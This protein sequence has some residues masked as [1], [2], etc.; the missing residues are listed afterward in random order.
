MARQP[1]RIEATGLEKARALFTRLKDLGRDPIGLMEAWAAV[2]ENSTRT[3][4]DTG[5]APGGVP[6]PPSKRVIRDGGKTLVDKGNLESSIRS[7]ASSTELEVG[8]DGVGASSRFAYVHQFGFQG[9]VQVPG[10]DRTISEAFGLPLPAPKTVAV[11]PHSRA[12]NIPQREFLGIDDDDKRD[13]RE[14]ALELLR[15]ITNG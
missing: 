2:I 12:M 14:V 4:F 13:M 9:T 8:V 10:H 7:Q 3:R 6:W 5:R 15:D 1:I 11:K